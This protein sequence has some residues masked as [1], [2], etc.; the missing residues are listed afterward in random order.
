MT[1]GWKGVY[2]IFYLSMANDNSLPIIT[3]ADFIK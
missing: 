3:N 2:E 1:A